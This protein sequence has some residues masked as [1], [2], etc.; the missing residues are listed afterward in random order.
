MQ[1]NYLEALLV[2]RF[3]NYYFI[4]VTNVNEN[5][6][7]PSFC[8][9]PRSWITKCLSLTDTLGFNSDLSDPSDPEILQPHPRFQDQNGANTAPSTHAAR[10]RLPARILSKDA[11]DRRKRLQSPHLAAACFQFTATDDRNPRNG[12]I[13]YTPRFGRQDQLLC[14]VQN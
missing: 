5:P 10:V 6:L 9:I 2:F 7:L 14:K 1:K 3:F 4:S 11:S 13:V 12:G 8:H